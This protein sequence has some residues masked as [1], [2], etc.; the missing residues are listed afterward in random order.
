MLFVATGHGRLLASL[1]IC[2]HDTHVMPRLTCV[3]QLHESWHTLHWLVYK[4]NARTHRHVSHVL[5]SCADHGRASNVDVLHT[6][7]KRRGGGGGDG[8]AERV[9]VDHHL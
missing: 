3:W 7:V 8:A 4:F 1:T 5:C 9:Q 2:I 6:M